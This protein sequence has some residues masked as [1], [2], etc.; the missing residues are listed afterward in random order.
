MF[1]VIFT[2]FVPFVELSLC[3]IRM[4]IFFQIYTFNISPIVKPIIFLFFYLFSE[5]TLYTFYKL[6]TI[7]NQ[8]MIAFVEYLKQN[9]ERFNMYL[10]KSLR[11]TKRIRTV[12]NRVNIIC[13]ALT[14]KLAACFLILEQRIANIF[15]YDEN[16]LDLAIDFVKNLPAEYKS[17]SFTD[18]NVLALELAI[19][20]S[21]NCRSSQL[22]YILKRTTQIAYVRRLIIN[23]TY[24]RLQ[25]DTNVY[26]WTVE[27]LEKYK[28]Y[29]L[30]NIRE[31]STTI[32]IINRRLLQEEMTPIPTNEDYKN[33]FVEDVLN[34]EIVDNTWKEEIPSECPVCY[35]NVCRDDCLS[36][37]HYIHKEC[38]IQS[39][40][41]S[42]AMCRKEVKLTKEDA[43]KLFNTLQ[44]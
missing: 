30:D 42:C 16:I 39:K 27:F 20:K 28:D 15:H 22:N 24:T 11:F 2:H 43:E 29:A 38:I 8:T 18:P 26:N 5:E 31:L 1:G 32:Q 3:S 44:N 40:K 6:F 34:R 25:Y 35:E 9:N 21:L 36:C 37:G 7:I 14:L 10:T 4:L 41:T 13:K 33:K 12:G 23:V 19:E 17:E